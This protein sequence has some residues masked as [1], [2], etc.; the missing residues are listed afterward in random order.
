M[1]YFSIKNQTISR[2][3]SFNVVGD[4]RKYLKAHFTFSEEWDGIN[5]A[6]F[7]NGE[8]VF[9][10]VLPDDNSCL[11][12]WEVI[13]PPYF[14]VSVFGGD[15]IT[16]NIVSVAVE[17]SG[18]TEGETPEE[19][20]PDVYT[21]ILQKLDE[22]SSPGGGGASVEIDKT[23]SK[24]G[25]AADAKATGD[26]IAEMTPKKGVDYWTKADIAEIKSYVDDAILGG[27]W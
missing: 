18:Y 2:S 21:Q 1:L 22:L 26:K 17:K 7:K 11:V 4:S 25:A 8:D 24:E 15:L 10:V 13:K 19:P 23:L 20:T 14:T 16:A 9:C 12:P 5:T 27:V 6:V 3:D